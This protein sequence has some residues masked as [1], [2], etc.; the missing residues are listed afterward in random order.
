[1]RAATPTRGRP[2]P[3]AD[4]T[5]FQPRRPAF[6][7]YLAIL[8]ATGFVLFGE[9]SFFHRMSPVGWL[10]SWA[11]LA[12][13]ALPVFLLVYLL[14]L[15]EREP[16]SLV[17]GALLWGAIAA[18]TLAGYA[19]DGWGLVVARVGGPAFAA[20]WTAALTAP[21]VEEMLKGLGVVLI[22]LIAPGE[23]DDM[24]DGFVYGAVCGLGF[25]VVEDVF[26]FMGVFGG[27]PSGVLKG[28]FVRVVAS[29]LYSHVLYTG[30][31]GMGIGY[32]VSRRERRPL[33]RRV[34]VVAGLSAVAVLAHFLWDSPLLDLF[35]ARPWSGTDWLV[36]PLATAVK[37]L[38]LLVF[39]VV[40][41]VLARRRERKWLE[42]ALAGEVGASGVSAAELLV[43]ERP[44]R[45]RAAVRDMR[46]RAGPR[47]GALLRR[48]HREQVT[49]AMIRSK[50]AVDDDPGLVAQR[51][52]CGSLRDALRA[53]PGA[54]PADANVADRLPTDAGSADR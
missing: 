39:V 52:Y 50:V 12:I 41:V 20:R 43:L 9:Q 48:L 24:M 19:N 31:V 13:Y 27:R 25:A 54:A 46:R 33:G 44:K 21:F 32:V 51:A 2:S 53:I 11:L 10:L 6:W 40:A 49:L 7:V 35:P 42:T 17:I 15:Y 47:A 16:L 4:G 28:F 30:L 45:R 3:L 22:Y 14:D 8:A 38:P 18:T 1:M 37:G 5:I 29:G 34:A 36:I 23:V 26:Y